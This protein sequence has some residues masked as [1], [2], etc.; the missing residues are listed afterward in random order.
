MPNFAFH[1]CSST[2]SIPAGATARALLT[3]VIRRLTAAPPVLH[4]LD[5]PSADRGVN[6]ARRTV[7]LHC[8]WQMVTDPDGTHRLKANW[9]PKRCTLSAPHQPP[10]QPTT[11][12]TSYSMAMPGPGSQVMPGGAVTV[13]AV[14]KRRT[15]LRP[16]GIRGRR[17]ATLRWS[18]DIPRR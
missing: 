18:H 16:T 15:R 5:R 8:R 6:A 11:V 2:P 17:P 3:G 7:P 10:T 13:D 9:Y 12:S 14:V 4:G 1:P